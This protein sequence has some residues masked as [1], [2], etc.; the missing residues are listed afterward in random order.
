V[1]G[2]IFDLTTGKVSP[3]TG[4]ATNLQAFPVSVEG[5]DLSI[6]IAERGQ[7]SPNPQAV[8]GCRRSECVS[9]SRLRLC[10][11]NRSRSNSGGPA[12]ECPFDVYA[13]APSDADLLQ[14]T[15]WVVTRHQ[16][17]VA[18]LKDPTR[19][20]SAQSLSV[21][22]TVPAEVQAVLDNGYPATPTMVT[23]DPPLHK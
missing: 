17:I 13:R 20:S 3:E 5:D 15:L 18:I 1:H 10:C 2:A 4:W 22:S 14:R 16:D 19:F 7:S 12:S 6:E 8:A 11:R 21:D 23:A 9:M